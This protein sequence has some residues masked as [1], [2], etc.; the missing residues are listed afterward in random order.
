MDFCGGYLEK[1]LSKDSKITVMLMG[2]AGVAI[3]EIFIYAYRGIV[4]STNIEIWLFIKILLIEVIFN[5]LITI[6]IYQGMQKLGYKIEEIF[7]NPQILT[8]YF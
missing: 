5:T 4:L 7:K 3:Y 6:I 8:R 2:A 1:N